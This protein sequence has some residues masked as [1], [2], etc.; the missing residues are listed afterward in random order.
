MQQRVLGQVARITLPSLGG[1]DDVFCEKLP[2]GRT[3]SFFG[4]WR[5]AGLKLCPCVIEGGNQ[6]FDFLRQKDRV[7]ML[8]DKEMHRVARIERSGPP[9]RRTTKPEQHVYMPDSVR[10]IQRLV[11][12]KVIAVK[13]DQVKRRKGTRAGHRAALSK[14]AAARTSTFGIGHHLPYLVLVGVVTPVATPMPLSRSTTASSALSAIPRHRSAAPA[15][16]APAG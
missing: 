9:P 2:C 12:H 8:L 3:I 13:L 16:S 6:N 7:G 5:S 1:H 4:N 11:N 10:A 15:P 14:S